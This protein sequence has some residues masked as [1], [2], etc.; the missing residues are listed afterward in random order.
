MA[1]KEA[2]FG[3]GCF[4][5]IEAIF[6]DVKGIKEVQSGY[7]GGHIKNPAYREVC[8]GTTGH[9]EVARIV[10]D[11]DFVSFDKLLEIFWYVHDPTTLNRQGNDVGEQYRSV[12]FYHD[13]KQKKK[14]E[15]YKSKLDESGAFDKKIV[16]EI[17]P[18]K[19]FY[20]A[21]DDHKDYYARNP[22]QPYCQ[23]VVR[24]KIEKF[25]NAFAE[26]LK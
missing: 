1:I 26:I 25:K 5:C 10:F 20:K 16:T 18:L 9:A 6:S 4:W 3:A 12:V 24:P 15:L 19:N 11:D 7:S 22:T 13:D 17:E 8:M 21:E 23:A 14:A 2:T